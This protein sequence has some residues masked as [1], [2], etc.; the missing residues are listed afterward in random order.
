[1][2]NPQV[3]GELAAILSVALLYDLLR[4]KNARL[5]NRALPLRRVVSRPSEPK[6]A[7]SPTAIAAIARGAMPRRES[8]ALPVLPPVIQDASVLARLISRRQQVS[9]LVWITRLPEASVRS[10]IGPEAFAAPLDS[11]EF[12]VIYPN[13]R[14]ASIGPLTRSAVE[15]DSQPIDRAIEIARKRADVSVELWNRKKT[16]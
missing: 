14:A 15:I 10:L 5:D 9:G 13:P 11:G 1:M 12:L 7:A 4:W 16:G 8:S 3:L 6:R 2:D